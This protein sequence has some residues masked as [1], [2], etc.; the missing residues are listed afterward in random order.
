VLPQQDKGPLLFYN[1]GLCYSRW[2]KKDMAREFLKIALIK[3]PNY[4]KAR[5]LLSQLE[6]GAEAA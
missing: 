1:I 5:K 3:E 6:T 4:R 2:G